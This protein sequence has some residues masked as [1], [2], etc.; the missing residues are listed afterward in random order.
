[1]LRQSYCPVVASSRMAASIQKDSSVV[2]PTPSSQTAPGT[3]IA[4]VG[5]APGLFG[6]VTTA[7]PQGSVFSPLANSTMMLAPPGNRRWKEVFL[8]AKS[9]YIRFMW[10][11]VVGVVIY[12][13][14]LFSFIAHQATT[15][16]K[17]YYK[18]TTRKYEVEC[19][20]VQGIL[21]AY[22]VWTGLGMLY[23]KVFG[24]NRLDVSGGLPVS[25]QQ[26]LMVAQ[27][28]VK[29]VTQAYA[30][31]TTGEEE[32]KREKK[33][34]QA[35][36][37]KDKE[38]IR[39]MRNYAGLSTW[40][41]FYIHFELIAETVGWS[42]EEKR[43]RMIL[44]LRTKA[45]AFLNG[46]P[47]DKKKT[48]QEVVDLLKDRFGPHKERQIYMA[49]AESRRM[50]KGENFREFG[51]A[52]EE[53]LRKAYP[54]DP[55]SVEHF[56]VQF[57]RAN[58]GNGA[59][60]EHIAI[61]KPEDVTAAITA[62]QY[63]Q[64][65]MKPIQEKAK[66][67]A[68][69]EGKS[70]KPGSVKALTATEDVDRPAS[71]DFSG[72][73]GRGGRRGRGGNS[74]GG[75]GGGYVAP[76]A[77]G[78]YYAQPAPV[79]YNAPPAQASYY[80]PP[81]NNNYYVPNKSIYCYRCGEDG[82]IARGCQDLYNPRLVAYKDRTVGRQVRPS[83]P[84]QAPGGW[85]AQPNPPTQTQFY[86]NMDSSTGRGAPGGR[87]TGRGGGVG[88]GSLAP[89]NHSNTNNAGLNSNGDGQRA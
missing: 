76:P 87:G 30:A 24:D 80:T 14:Y 7:T 2:P 74:R 10:F 3:P 33:K 5:P 77:P 19:N 28:V 42:I 64:D 53:L 35:L 66:E 71:G 45:D 60:Q 81:A 37:L 63:W 88:R 13:V 11:M 40:K 15:T 22:M 44:Q 9:H 26:P 34:N 23:S 54:D 89:Q 67:E 27:P 49:E 59:I 72:R 50:K 83:Y 17:E 86:H 31:Q 46:I 32:E 70:H 12:G 48:Y 8:A 84:G 79:N 73:G 85:P 16:L 51:Q 55:K 65:V 56:A 78:G 20:M 52:I 43:L 69:K 18:W 68:K 38:I 41:D 21:V 47:E 6:P 75:G 4:P 1:M 29:S 39:N 36:H 58:C 62:A 25:P 82:H 57:F 61:A